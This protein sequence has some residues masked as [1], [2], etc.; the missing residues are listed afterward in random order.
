MLTNLL[1]DFPEMAIATD[2]VDAELVRQPRR[3]NITFIRKF[4]FTFGLISSIFDYLTFFILRY[5]FH[6]SAPIF[7]TGWFLESVIS[8]SL[9]VLVIRSRQPFFK[10][11][12]G[13]Y[14]AIAT[15]FIVIVTLLLP[16]TPLAG[17]LGFQPLPL[18][19]ILAILLIV[20]IYIVTA[21]IAKQSFYKRVKD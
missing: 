9:I 3:W 11:R 1:T 19:M 6:A 16:Y 4:M 10:S 12:P 7:R 8:A 15:V 5:F 2:A 18:T 14:L 17:L 20:A 13:K 21:E